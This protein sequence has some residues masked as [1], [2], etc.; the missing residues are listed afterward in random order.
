MLV[1][2]SANPSSCR[3]VS[4]DT[5]LSS[6]YS[7]PPF[8]PSHCRSLRHSIMMTEQLYRIKALRPAKPRAEEMKE[9]ASGHKV[10]GVGQEKRYKRNRGSSISANARPERKQQARKRPMKSARQRDKKIARRSRGEG[11]SNS[12]SEYAFAATVAFRHSQ[13]LV[14]MIRE[15]KLR[16]RNF[17]IGSVEICNT[18]LWRCEWFERLDVRKLFVVSLSIRAGSGG[19]WWGLHRQPDSCATKSKTRHNGGN[20][21]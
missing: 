7:M 18:R 13:L 16:K 1:A 2:L 5:N 19:L 11:E 15:V 6:C 4:R 8:S 21:R 9:S 20:T 3:P 10:Q 14:Y 17:N 12:I